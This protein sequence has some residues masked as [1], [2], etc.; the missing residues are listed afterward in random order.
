MLSVL[1]WLPAVTP[2]QVAQAASVCTG[3]TSTRVPPSKIRVLRTSGTSSGYVQ[4]ADFKK[5]VQIV[6]AAEW[7]PNWPAAALK[8]GAIAVKQY[9][10]YYTM[11]WRGGTA[12]GACYD[13]VDNTNDQVYQPESRTP[14]AA[15]L[16]AI[17]ATWKESV[18]KNGSFLMTGYRSGTSYIRC[19]VDADGWHLFQHSSVDCA[20]QG[21]TA[22]Q[23]LHVYF[24]PGMATW[25]PPIKPATIFLFP[26]A[27][28]QV[29]ARTS[30]SVSWVEET[31]GGTTVTHRAL[32]LLMALP[33]N[34]KCTVD[35]WVPA[36]P[37]WQSTGGSPQAITGLKAGYCYRLVLQLTDSNSVKTLS[38]S[39]TMLVDPAA[40]TAAFTSPAPNA[41]TAIGGTTATVRWT[42]TPAGGT[43]IVSRKLTT[44]WAAQPEA[45]TCAGTQW[46][47]L[48]STTA[49]SPVS[50]GGLLKL[51]C[52]RYRLA[53]TDSAGHTS[54][55]ISA[56]FRA[57]SA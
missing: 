6:M 16:A 42:E 56:E 49:G 47:T 17:E 43:H 52:Y 27:Q 5:Y 21:M 9:G 11:H 3:W 18:T 48:T 40:A 26:A 32:S 41:V 15:A 19:G 51:Y 4:T 55:T 8:S 45:G 1:V 31:T 54:T 50:V 12:H 30:A 23:I 35:R 38:Q 25:T 57:P 28:S 13:V 24:D 36:S 34:G 14:S 22:D 44:E 39:G 20:N 46:S 29:T 7:P 2:P 53:L 33:I 10:W 37:S